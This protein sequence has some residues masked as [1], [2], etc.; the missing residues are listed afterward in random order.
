MIRINFFS[1]PYVVY[2]GNIPLYQTSMFFDT[3]TIGASTEWGGL[4]TLPPQAIIVA[5]KVNLKETHYFAS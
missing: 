3:R 5:T 4:L 1:E 2:W